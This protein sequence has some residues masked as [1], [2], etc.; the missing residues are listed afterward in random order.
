M[1]VTVALCAAV[2]RLGFF[3]KK[4]RQISVV[5]RVGLVA[6][7]PSRNQAPRQ[8]GE[9]LLDEPPRLRRHGGTIFRETQ[10]GPGHEAAALCSELGEK[11]AGFD[12]PVPGWRGDMV[13][14][15]RVDSLTILSFGLAQQGNAWRDW[16]APFVE[17][18]EGLLHSPAWAEFWLYLTDRHALPRRWMRWAH[19]FAQRFRTV[20]RGPPGDAQLFT[21]FLE[22]DVV[23]TA[24]KA[25][26]DILEEC[27]SYAPC[28]LPDG[29]LVPAGAPG[30]EELLRMLDPR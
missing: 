9:G 27:R 23:V 4:E 3:D 26:I 10:D 17:L 13:E 28:D 20:T 5:D 8:L 2:M 16:I 25:L 29:K 24:D 22:T 21:Y 1:K 19:S 15:W 12:G 7:A 18:D 11:R 30:V 14:A 6:F